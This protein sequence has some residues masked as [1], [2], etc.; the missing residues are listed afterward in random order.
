MND[1]DFCTDSKGYQP[2]V[3]DRVRVVLEGE[4]YDTFSDHFNISHAGARGGNGIFPRASHVVS[5]E[6]LGPKLPTKLGSVVRAGGITYVCA[7]GGF[8]FNQLGH[9]MYDYALGRQNFTIIYDPSK[10]N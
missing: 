5:I 8:W 9:A 4:V 6:K 2:R 7:Q 3:G 10:E 1:D